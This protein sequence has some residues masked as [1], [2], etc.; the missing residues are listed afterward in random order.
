VPTVS[1]VMACLKMMGRDHCLDDA[2]H[3][4]GVGT[5]TLNRFYHQPTNFLNA[6]FESECGPPSTLD[7]LE[8]TMA[9]YAKVFLDALAAQ[10]AFTLRG[11]AV[12]RCSAHCISEAITRRPPSCFRCATSTHPSPHPPTHA[13]PHPFLTH[14]T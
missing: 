3:E 9:D 6:R 4:F 11:I 1:L 13:Q 12:R 14:L 2:S 7:Q 5:S 10:N 8:A